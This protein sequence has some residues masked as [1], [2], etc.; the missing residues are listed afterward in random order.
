M[1]YDSSPTPQRD[2][3]DEISFSQPNTDAMRILL[4]NKFYFPQGGAERHVLQLQELLTVHGH[5]V[6]IFSMA[7][8]QNLPSPYSRYFVSRVD[9]DRVR[10]DWQ[11]LRAIGRMVYSWE[12][13][14]KLS[15][16]IRATKPDVA[17]IHNIYHQISPSILDTL[18]RWHVPVVSTLHDYHL[19]SPNYL[20]F[21][22]GAVCERSKPMRYW[23]SVAH[24]CVKNSVAASAAAALALYIHRLLRLYRGVHTYISP[25]RFL[26]EQMR[27]WGFPAHRIVE[28]PNFVEPASAG[29]GAG[30]FL[31][32]AG[33]LAPEKGVE[34]LLRAAHATN[35]PLVFAGTGPEEQRLRL[36]Q[37]QLNA[38]TVRFVGQ[39]SAAHMQRLLAEC[40]AVVV[41]SLCYEN[42]PLTILEAFAHGKPVIASHL[43]GIPELVHDG[44]NGW[45]TVPGSVESVSAALR[46][47]MTADAGAY[48]QMSAAAATTAS[49]HGPEQYYARLMEIY[50]HAQRT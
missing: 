9:F 26:H 22:H 30:V 35:T 5:E 33:R 31:L 11:G 46:R 15:A 12:A 39:Q 21:D 25:S 8:P 45:L 47:A 36:L 1:L 18:R 4:I 28:L 6:I 27:S 17:H 41:P 37:R 29:Q 40:R 38:T 50:A 42:C 19:L 44:V 14:R 7:H 34:T 10:Y 13:R 16:L 48:G 2:A 24:R 3:E 20:L 32:F 43:G 49:R 23:R